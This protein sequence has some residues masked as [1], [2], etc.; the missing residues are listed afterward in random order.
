M[1]ANFS[2]LVEDV[3]EVE[4]RGGGGVC[5]WKTPLPP[6]LYTTKRIGL[7]NDRFFYERTI[8]FLKILKKRLL[9]HEQTIV[10]MKILLNDRSVRYD[11]NRWKLK[12]NFKNKQNLLFERWKKRTKRVIHK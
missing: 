1:F 9:F 4:T 6:N 10:S 11:R 3:I 2:G 7:K 8:F 12:Y 5:A